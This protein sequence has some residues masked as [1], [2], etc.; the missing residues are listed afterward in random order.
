MAVISENKI[1]KT[2]DF[3]ACNYFSL[4]IIRFFRKFVST[5]WI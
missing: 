2:E 1:L 5:F 3:P 4:A